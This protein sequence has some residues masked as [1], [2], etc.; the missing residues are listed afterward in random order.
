MD[1]QTFLKKHYFWILFGVAILIVPV[2]WWLGTKK[3]AAETQQ[4]ISDIEAAESG[5]PNAAGHPNKEWAKQLEIVN[6]TR[7]EHHYKQALRLWNL[8]RGIMQWPTAVQ[9][10][11]QDAEFFEPGQADTV[12][13]ANRARNTYADIYVQHA[14][15]VYELVRPIHYDEQKEKYVGLVE[16]HF[17]KRR[18]N[19]AGGMGRAGGAGPMGLGGLRGGAG[20][21]GGAGGGIAGANGVFPRVPYTLWENRSPTFREMWKAQLD[22]WLLKA[23][24]QSVDRVNETRGARTI[25]DAS[26][27]K[28]AHLSLHGGSRTEDGAGATGEG[29]SEAAQTAEGAYGGKNMSVPGIGT[30]GTSGGLTGNTGEGAGAGSGAAATGDVPIPPPPEIFGPEVPDE[31]EANGETSGEGGDTETTATNMNAGFSPGGRG[32]YG[33]G[34]TGQIANASP[35]VDNDPAMPFKTRGFIIKVLMKRTDIPLL[36]QELTDANKTKFPVEILWVN[37]VDRDL[38]HRGDKVL[39]RYGTGAG[40]GVVPGGIGGMGDSGEPSPMGSRRFSPG[41]GGVPMTGVGRGETGSGTGNNAPYQSAL[42]DPAL[43]YVVVAGLMTIYQRPKKPESTEGDN[44]PADP[45]TDGKT[46]GKKSGLKTPKKA[47][48]KTKTKSNPTDGKSPSVKPE[49]KTK[50]PSSE[51][52]QEAPGKQPKKSGGFRKPAGTPSKS[53]PTK[54]KTPAKNQPNEKTSPMNEKPSGTAPKG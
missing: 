21:G 48:P 47:G 4:R 34:G 8:Q 31:T 35:W 6:E 24:L 27:R 1:F 52:S 51:D 42:N 3:L 54:K 45:K 38:D 43:G 19:N 15:S 26:I 29:E 23:L 36:I 25:N 13:E 28:I 41:T 5:I 33:G 16:F 53:P 14:K 40:A 37:S 32:A 49:K 7:K 20:E 30:P 10:V 17:P 12:Q 18:E 44:K 9:H 50:T 11:M 22:L 39:L 2:G 46:D